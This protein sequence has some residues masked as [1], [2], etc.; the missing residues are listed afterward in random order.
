M[1][2]SALH[3]DCRH[4]RAGRIVS[5][6]AGIE[7]LH[8]A[9]LVGVGRKGAAAGKSVVGASFSRAV[10]SG[11]GRLT[12]RIP[13]FSLGGANRSS[14]PI[15]DVQSDGSAEWQLLLIV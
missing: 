3:M 9:R 4:L 15:P 11:E 8:R 5:K 7:G 12:E 14:C 10:P 13:A 1:S 2:G 6:P